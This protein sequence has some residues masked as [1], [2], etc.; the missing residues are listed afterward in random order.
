M[1][2]K[3]VTRLVGRWDEIVPTAI[4]NSAKLTGIHQQEA[5]RKVLH[6]VRSNNLRQFDEMHVD[7]ENRRHPVLA[8]ARASPQSADIPL[9]VPRPSLHLEDARGVSGVIHQSRAPRLCTYEEM[10]LTYYRNE[11]A[12]EEK[13]KQLA[14]A[15]TTAQI[16]PISYMREVNSTN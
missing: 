5:I 8:S 2:E 11:E 7:W 9:H 6:V 13:R 4:R 16:L 12:L 14:R 1:L 15:T 10:E 3:E